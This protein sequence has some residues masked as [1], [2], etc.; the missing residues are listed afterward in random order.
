LPDHGC[1]AAKE[2]ALEQEIATPRVPIAE[3]PRHMKEEEL[4]P[5]TVTMPPPAP[6]GQCM[7]ELQQSS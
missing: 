1:D 5:E 3:T 7:Q 6:N 4:L 2:P